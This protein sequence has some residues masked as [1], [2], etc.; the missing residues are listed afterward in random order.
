MDLH[1]AAIDIRNAPLGGALVTLIFKAE[2]EEE[3]MTRETH[4]R[5]AATGIVSAA[6]SG[7]P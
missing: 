6:R 5:G 2:P 4:S 7:Q 3:A 1:G